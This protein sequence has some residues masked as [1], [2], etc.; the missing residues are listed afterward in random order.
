MAPHAH[1][2]ASIGTKKHKT[3]VAIRQHALLL[4]E[5]VASGGQDLG[6]NPIETLAA[7]LGA[8]TSITLRLY[9]DRK[10]WPLTGVVVDVDIDWRANPPSAARVLRIHGDALTPDM[11]ARLLQI[12][13]ACPVHKM[14]AGTTAVSTRVGEMP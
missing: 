12:A 2:H 6:P 11:R 13:D 4:D 5:D 3:E 10:G 7:A 8:C 1:A 14:L 9:A